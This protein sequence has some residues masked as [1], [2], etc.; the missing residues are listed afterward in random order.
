MSPL[1]VA[2]VLGRPHDTSTQMINLR[3]SWGG[4]VLGIAAF[5]VWLPALRPWLR[6]AAGLLTWVMAGVGLA[7]VV[8]FALDGHPDAR[9]Y[10]WIT[11]EVV[12]TAL[13]AWALRGLA[14]RSRRATVR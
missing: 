12:L 11:G 9:Q 13:G 8:G 6:S 5:V 10:V 7:R 4:L 3:A 1:A 2:E 14:R